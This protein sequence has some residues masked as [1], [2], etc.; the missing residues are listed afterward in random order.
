MAISKEKII[1]VAQECAELL[2][3]GIFYT[4]DYAVDN[5]IVVYTKDGNSVSIH[6]DE[7]DLSVDRFYRLTEV[8]L[9]EV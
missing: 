3:G 7:L 1:E 6:V 4:I 2:H 8:N 9:N 5:V